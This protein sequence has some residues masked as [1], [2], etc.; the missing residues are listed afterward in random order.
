MKTWKKVLIIVVSVI[1]AIAIA[2]AGTMIYLINTGQSELFDAN[3]NV[4]VPEEV[5]AQVQDDGDYIEYKGATYQYNKD[6]TNILFLGIDKNLDEENEMSTGGQADMLVMIAMNT[7][8]HKMTMIAIPRD[9]MTE[10]AL[11]TPSGRYTG[12]DTMQV[13]LAYA[14]GDG[15]ETSCENTVSSARKIFYNIP[16]KTYY[17]LDLDGIAAMNDCVGGIDVVSPETITSFVKGESYHLVG[18]Q[19]EHFVRDRDQTTVNASLQRLERQKVYAKSFLATM[20]SKIKSDVTSAVSVFNDSAP[21]SCTNLN[22]AKVAYLA[23]EFAFGGGMTTEMISIP[24]KMENN[25]DRAEYKID[26]NAFFEQFLSVYYE[27]VR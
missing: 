10:V 25:N 27:R 17:A 4:I 16:V 15:K 7:K 3:L 2:V 18:R 21:Y 1:L 24:G 20:L 23:K 14:Y 11:Y 19:A 22:A 8:K 6:V 26:E 5:P 9:T 13:C 12:M